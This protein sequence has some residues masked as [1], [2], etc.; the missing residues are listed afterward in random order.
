MGVRKLN[1]ALPFYVVEH[2]QNEQSYWVP[3]TCIIVNLALHSGKPIFIREAPVPPLHS[4]TVRNTVI[5]QVVDAL[6]IQDFERCDPE[7]DAT[8][9]KLAACWQSV[10]EY[11]GLERHKGVP[12]WM[13][14]KQQLAAGTEIKICYGK[15]HATAGAHQEHPKVF[16]EIHV[17]LGGIGRVEKWSDCGA[18]SLYQQYILAPGSTHDSL[19]D[20]KGCYPWHRYYSITHVTFL[21]IEIDRDL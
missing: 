2:V 18:D 1:F 19:C 10:W 7:D 6:I 13:T 11:S 8:Q 5:E 4:A 9:Q 14:P 16:D 21:V 20:K 12:F 3:G 15:P 17:Q